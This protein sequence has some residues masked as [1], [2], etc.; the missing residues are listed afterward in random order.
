MML[1][2][3]G[4]AVFVASFKGAHGVQ[5]KPVTEF[6]LIRTKSVLS[7]GIHV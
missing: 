7:L 6:V 4:F 3:S 2:R 1:T 5:P